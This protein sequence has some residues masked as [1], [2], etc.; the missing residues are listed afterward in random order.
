[1]TSE[2]RNHRVI[3]AAIAAMSLWVFAPTAHAA[4]CLDQQMGIKVYEAPGVDLRQIL[5][6]LLQE[7]KLSAHISRRVKGTVTGAYQGTMKSFYRR[8]LRR[9]SLTSVELGGAFYIY[10]ADETT[11]SAYSVPPE[12]LGSVLRASR[13]TGMRSDAAQLIPD[14]AIGRLV[15]TAP[16][17]FQKEMADIVAQ[18][19]RAK[20]PAL[21]QQTKVFR[22]GY[23]TADDTVSKTIEGERRVKGLASILR[24][25]LPRDGPDAAG[26]ATAAVSQESDGRRARDVGAPL[27][28]TYSIGSLIGDPDAAAGSAREEGARSAAR[29]STDPRTNSIIV[30][31]SKQT[32]RMAEK[33]IR[34]LDVPSQQIQIEA[35]I[36]ELE[37]SYLDQFGIDLG[38]GSRNVKI[39]SAT[40]LV[41]WSPSS[42]AQVADLISVGSSVAGNMTGLLTYGANQLLARIRALQ[43]QGVARIVSTPSILTTEN[44]EASIESSDVMYAKIYGY[45]SGQIQQI[46]GGMKLFVRG[47]ILDDSRG[48]NL[49]IRIEDAVARDAQVDG[50]PTFR[51]NNI[52]TQAVVPEGMSIVIGGLNVEEKSKSASGVPGLRDIPL[53]GRLFSGS[54]DQIKEKVRM[55]LVEPR[56]LP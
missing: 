45:Q 35:T 6:D 52:T 17:I 47:V 22:L 3:S 27:D 46:E 2:T 15:V 30:T 36:F 21:A 1:M 32:L 40:R 18:T 28:T 23:S 44:M 9:H 43:S 49:S 53:L 26:G 7:C 14:H 11:T 12:L 24:S 34:T 13:A 48:I 25:A 55:V 29:V 51:V 41:D 19:V 33:I 50:I 56:I 54:T 20:G 5:G 38:F 39:G 42:G 10:T 37:K 8:L 31:G 4:S 16:P